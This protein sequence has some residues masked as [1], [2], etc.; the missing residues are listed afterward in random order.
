ML[1]LKSC[2]LD[3]EFSEQATIKLLSSQGRRNDLVFGV[4]I[5]LKQ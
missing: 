4:A 1:A 3:F 5:E 2:L